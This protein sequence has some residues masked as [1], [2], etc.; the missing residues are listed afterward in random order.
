MV[1]LLSVDEGD[2]STC[3]LDFARRWTLASLKLFLW[4]GMPEGAFAG[5]GLGA[6][7]EAE[8]REFPLRTDLIVWGVADSSATG[9]EGGPL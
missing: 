6:A 5:L 3:G 2:V 9:G 1:S 7:I 8:L 4:R